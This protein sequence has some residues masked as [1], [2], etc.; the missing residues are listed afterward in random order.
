MGNAMG[1]DAYGMTS[2]LV[3]IRNEVRNMNR[4]FDRLQKSI[5]SINEDNKKLKAQNRELKEQVEDLS[6]TLEKLA[7]KSAEIEQ[8]N[9]RLEAQSRRQ[10]LK[11]YGIPE[12]NKETWDES[13]KKER[14]Y[15]SEEIEIDETQIRI[16]RAHRLR[17]KTSPRPIIVRFS[18][19]KERNEVLKVYSQKEKRDSQSSEGSGDNRDNQNANQDRNSY[20]KDIRLWWT[21]NE[22]SD[23]TLSIY[24]RLLESGERGLS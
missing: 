19:F 10:N 1:A 22:G 9:E 3:D 12:S 4:M 21:C 15:I 17:S 13:E 16:E 7:K 6:V 20:M 5:D 23:S 24:A 18:F 14:G 11:F 8:K 2:I